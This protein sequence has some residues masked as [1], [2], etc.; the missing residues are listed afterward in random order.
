M[1]ANVAILKN[2][3]YLETVTAEILICYTKCHEQYL[4]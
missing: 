1:N 3:I 2:L 4:P